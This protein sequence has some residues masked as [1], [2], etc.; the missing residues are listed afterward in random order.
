[1]EKI[2]G[3]KVIFILDDYTLHIESLFKDQCREKNEPIPNRSEIIRNLYRN[4]I[5]E[6]TI[7]KG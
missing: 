6:R 3:K 2:D 4:Y 7:I 5:Q 1:M